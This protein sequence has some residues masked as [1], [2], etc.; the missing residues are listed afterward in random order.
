MTKV[1]KLLGGG[2]LA[3]VLSIVLVAALIGLFNSDGGANA[4]TPTFDRASARLIG[5]ADLAPAS[6]A[7][8][9]IRTLPGDIYATNTASAAGSSNPLNA[10]PASLVSALNT[11]GTIPSSAFDPNAPSIAVSSLPQ[12]GSSV[13]RAT[14]GVSIDFLNDDGGRTSAIERTSGDTVQL[15]DSFV[16]ASRPT[17]SDSVLGKDNLF[18]STVGSGATS[19]PDDQLSMVNPA[20]MASISVSMKSQPWTKVANNDNNLGASLGT[21]HEA[22][23]QTHV[24]TTALSSPAFLVIGLVA[25]FAATCVLMVTSSGFSATNQ[26]AARA[27][28]AG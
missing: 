9:P 21:T 3:A 7:A 2:W 17:R 10:L 13:L 24:D 1:T 19:A 23:Y 25:L 26:R 18:G 14:T 15:I 8:V 28:G 5:S 4:A 22:W 16:P 20:S 6:S 27:L 12:V 11:Y